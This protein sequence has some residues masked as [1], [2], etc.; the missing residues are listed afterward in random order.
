MQLVATNDRQRAW[1]RALDH[2]RSTGVKPLYN[3][4]QDFYTVQSPRGMAIYFVVRDY[5]GRHT[6]WTCTCPAYYAGKVCWHRALV[7]ALPYERTLRAQRL[8]GVL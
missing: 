1:F 4:A 7:M 3:I 2:A 5:E 6:H 8:A